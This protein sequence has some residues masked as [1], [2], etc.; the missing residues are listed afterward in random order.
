MA[1]L[2][3]KKRKMS[4]LRRKK[5]GMIDSRTN[6]KGNTRPIALNIFQLIVL[7]RATVKP[8]ISDQPCDQKFVAVVDRW[9]LFRGNFMF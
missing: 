8:V 6:S 4:V 9:S 1:K 7:L 3:R 5:F 2:K